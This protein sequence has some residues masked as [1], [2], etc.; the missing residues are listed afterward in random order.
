M[1]KRELWIDKRMGRG[2]LRVEKRVLR[3]ESTVFFYLW[4]LYLL[5]TL[6]KV[7]EGVHYKTKRCFVGRTVKFLI[8]CFVMEENRSDGQIG[9]L[10]GFLR[11]LTTAL[12]PAKTYSEPSQTSELQLFTKTVN[13]LKP[14]TIFA[15]RSNLDV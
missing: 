13:G 2:V 11:K 3:V 9:Q 15:K 8:D 5:A 7:I 14:L 12:L 6:V 1:D 10:F 4:W